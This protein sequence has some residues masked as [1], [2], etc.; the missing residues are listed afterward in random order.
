MRRIGRRMVGTIMAA[1]ITD[2]PTTNPVK[3][4]RIGQTTMTSHPAQTTA[5][6]GATATMSALPQRFAEMAAVEARTSAL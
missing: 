1:L 6:T 3:S 2:Q 5:I 4:C